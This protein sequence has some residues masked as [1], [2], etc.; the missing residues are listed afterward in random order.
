[1]KKFKLFLSG[2][3]L[4]S[5]GMSTGFAE[6][7][8]IPLFKAKGCSLNMSCKAQTANFS[9]NP[10][11]KATLIADLTEVQEKLTCEEK[12]RGYPRS[13]DKTA[14]DCIAALTQTGLTGAQRSKILVTQAYATQ[15]LDNGTMASSEKIED[16]RA[17]KI[18]RL[19]IVADANNIEAYHGLANFYVMFGDKEGALYVYAEILKQRPLDANVLAHISN[20]YL[21]LGLKKQALARAEQAFAL[22]P[23]DAFANYALAAAHYENG[24]F[25]S[26]E[27]LLIQAQG[28]FH[29]IYESNYSYFK[30]LSPDLMLVGLYLQTQQP[31]KGLAL[32]NTY[33]PANG[34]SFESSVWLAARG[35]FHVALGQLTQA[36]D[37]FEAAAKSTDPETAVNYRQK[38]DQILLR[39]SSGAAVA[40]NIQA[41]LAL[42]K[43]KPIL[44]T[45][46]FLRAQGYKDVEITGVYDGPTQAALTSCLEDH[47]CEE[48][49]GKRAAEPVRP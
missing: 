41:E 48:G 14:K 43:L 10:K 32:V 17:A 6:S 34:N 35:N 12:E 13:P 7:D 18:F 8:Y 3:I 4:A 29:K 21:N 15:Q 23:K 28:N 33:F 30:Y 31:E 49:A 9:P 11:F 2:L 16:R 45:Q 37:D 20:L 46:I 38:R 44:R 1:M 47:L 27:K 36:A 26:A 25:I 5:L 24:N 22:N 40:G 19:A 39:T 42:G